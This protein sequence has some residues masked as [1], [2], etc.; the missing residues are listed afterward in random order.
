MDYD[1]GLILVFED[2]TST[3]TFWRILSALV[4]RILSA[5]AWRIHFGLS[6]G[7]YISAL[8]LRRGHGGFVDDLVALIDGGFAT[9]MTWRLVARVGG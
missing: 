7:G 4:W 5:L 6:I 2:Y 1:G 9:L 8:G 3:H